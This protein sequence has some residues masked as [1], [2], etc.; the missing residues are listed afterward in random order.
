MESGSARTTTDTPRTALPSPL[1]LPRSLAFLGAALSLFLS[2]M[3]AGAD[4]PTWRAVIE[5]R[6]WG[7]AVTALIVGPFGK[8]GS[9]TPLPETVSVKARREDMK[10]FE[11]CS[12][13]RITSYNVCYTKLL[14]DG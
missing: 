2:C 9:S 6:D 8:E 1:A 11:D 3:P 14:R 12:V 7:P 13:T 10:D 5:G 4:S